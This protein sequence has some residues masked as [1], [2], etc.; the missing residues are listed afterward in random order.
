MK[1]ITLYE[2]TTKEIMVED[3]Q[4]YVVY[5]QWPIERNQFI[6]PYDKA[7]SEVSLVSNDLPIRSFTNYSENRYP[8]DLTIDTTYIATTEDFNDLVQK[9]T[10]ETWESIDKIKNSNE[11]M[12]QTIKDL[13]AYKNRVNNLNFMDRLKY[14][15]TT[16]IK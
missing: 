11:N 12:K 5:Y 2:V 15:F 3:L 4:N 6:E 8:H 16:N 1:Q 14:L 13:R 7:V 10:G 9:A